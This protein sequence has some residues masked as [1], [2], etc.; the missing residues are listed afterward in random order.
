MIKEDIKPNTIYY[1][2]DFDTLAEVV[3]KTDE[4]KNSDLLKSEFIRRLGAYLINKSCMVLVSFGENKGLNACGVISRHIDKK[5]E[6]IWIDFRWCD[7][8][9][10]GLMG[11]FYDELINI[12]KVSG[13][14]RVQGRTNRGFKAINKLYGAYEIGRIYEIKVEGENNNDN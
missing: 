8:H 6:Y 3:K 11:K 2:S 4:V 5:G 10:M 1:T 13:I 14:K 7:P 9:S 12:C